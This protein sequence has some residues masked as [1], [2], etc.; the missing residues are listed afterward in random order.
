ME[1]DQLTCDVLKVLAQSNIEKMRYF[2]SWQEDR[3]YSFPD[4]SIDD[5]IEQPAECFAL[6]AAKTFHH[7]RGV[8]DQDPTWGS[9][10]DVW[11]VLEMALELR[12]TADYFWIIDPDKNLTGPLDDVWSVLSSLSRKALSERNMQLAG[13]QTSFAELLGYWGVSRSERRIPSQE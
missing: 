10:R 6:L 5:G 8:F 4:S 3:I 13:P 11:C 12:R 1:I 2:G 9:V 7:Y